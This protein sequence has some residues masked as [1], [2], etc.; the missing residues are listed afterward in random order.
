MSRFIRSI[1]GPKVPDEQLAKN[2]IRYGL[3]G[4]LL[5]LARVLLLISLFMPYWHMEL[6]APQYPDGLHMVAYI[7][8]L[9]GDV[10]E[11][12]GLNHYIGMRSLHDAAKF[13]RELGVFAMIA[14]VVMLELASAIRSH[15]AAVL[16]L[17]VIL[18]P[19]VFLLDLY[20]W[21][22]HFGLNLDPNA[23]LSNAIKPFVPTAL[24]EGGIGQFRTYAS[25]G[26]GL[27]LST[28]ASVVIIV[29]LFFHR[30]AYRPLKLAAASAAAG[31]D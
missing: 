20:L 8:N 14:F 15:W 3:P 27:W 21:M 10:A 6:K 12:D 1:L 24:G 23:P 29:A 17:P 16:V 4:A 30:R 5:L 13:E 28:A 9:S 2:S 19:A 18:F 7:N 22:R 11:I 26:I 31:K 25:A